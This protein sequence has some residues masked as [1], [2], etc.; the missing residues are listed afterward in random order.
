MLYSVNEQN[1]EA[2]LV[3][4]QSMR[5]FEESKENLETSTLAINNLA[6]IY[7]KFGGNSEKTLGFLDEGIEAA[8]KNTQDGASLLSNIGLIV[9]RERKFNEVENLLI[10]LNEND[11]M[12]DF[13]ENFPHEMSY[14]Q[15]A[16]DFFVDYCNIVKNFYKDDQQLH[17]AN[18]FRILGN[19]FLKLEDFGKAKENY[20]RAILEFEKQKEKINDDIKIE[21]GNI[22]SLM[23]IIW[24]SLNDLSEAKKYLNKAFDYYGNLI[25]NRDLRRTHLKNLQS[26]LEKY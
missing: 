2:G 1:N 15:K 12:R 19:T 23:I 6:S 21:L 18:S 3:L 26:K 20:E 14:Y 17:N 22:C 9:M 11:E 4:E 8:K 24:F 13:T 5:V 16:R 10:N 25:P 7:D